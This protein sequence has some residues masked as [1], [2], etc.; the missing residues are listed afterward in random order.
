[1]REKKHFLGLHLEKLIF[2]SSKSS[3]KAF[4]CLDKKIETGIFKETA[5]QNAN[6]M[7]NFC[8]IFNVWNINVGQICIL[9]HKLYIV[10]SSRGRGVSSDGLGYD[11]VGAAMSDISGDKSEVTLFSNGSS[12]LSPLLSLIAAPT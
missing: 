7:W 5:A 10:Y 9:Y 3:E 8:T 4:S 6:V 11:Y 1:L 12:V 2:Y